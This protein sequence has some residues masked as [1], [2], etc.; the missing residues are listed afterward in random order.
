MLVTMQLSFK[1]WNE[2]DDLGKKRQV[3]TFDCMVREIRPDKIFVLEFDDAYLLDL[4]PERKSLF[5]EVLEDYQIRHHGT[6]SI[7]PSVLKELDM[8]EPR[9][10]YPIGMWPNLRP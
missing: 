1:D 7:D 3:M 2:R 9:Y 10:F 8:E 5:Q 4:S 6:P